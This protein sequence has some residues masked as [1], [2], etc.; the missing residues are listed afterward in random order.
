[1]SVD[2]LFVHIGTLDEPQKIA[3]TLHTGVE[4]QMPRLHFDDDVP[5]IRCD[6]DAELA[7]AYAAGE[8]AK[9]QT[10]LKFISV[11]ISRSQP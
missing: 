10:L 1:M 3:I 11:I 4:S 2:K 8:A 9:L 6:E 5:R 7:A